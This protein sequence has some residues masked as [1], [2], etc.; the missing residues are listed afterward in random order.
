MLAEPKIFQ[1]AQ[2]PDI[3]PGQLRTGF[4]SYRSQL[5][6]RFCQRTLSCSGIGTAR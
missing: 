5:R 3:L 4:E 2:L 6:M 1:T